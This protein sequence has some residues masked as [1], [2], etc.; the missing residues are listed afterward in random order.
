MSQKINFEFFARA[1]V[2]KRVGIV[3]VATIFV[4]LAV[5]YGWFSIEISNDVLHYLTVILDAIG[6]VVAITVT[7]RGVTP[8][9]DPRSNSGVPLVP[10]DL[11]S[12]STIYAV[13]GDGPMKHPDMLSN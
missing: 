2:A 8:S 9:S 11:A 5:N 12:E 4:H 1:V 3:A 10:V 6:A 7:H 13:P